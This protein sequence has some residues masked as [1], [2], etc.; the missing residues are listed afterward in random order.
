MTAWAELSENER[1]IARDCF[2]ALKHVGR[3][4]CLVQDDLGDLMLS[5]GRSE[6]KPIADELEA[7]A[8]EVEKVSKQL[9]EFRG[10]LGV[11]SKVQ[12]PRSA[13]R[14]LP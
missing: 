4:L 6:A 12:H 8:D 10:R 14:S 11:L 2:S 9:Q 1:L 3:A 7:M 5:L 13:S